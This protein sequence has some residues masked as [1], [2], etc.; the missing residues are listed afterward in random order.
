[1]AKV[2]SNVVR[3][4]EEQIRDHLGKIVSGS[5]EE[6]IYVLLDSEADWLCNAGRGRGKCRRENGA[7]LKTIR[8]RVHGRYFPP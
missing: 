5:V 6:T 2:L 7:R 4:N 3:S 8:H 1:M